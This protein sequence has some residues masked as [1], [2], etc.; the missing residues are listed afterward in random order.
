M[1]VL[2]TNVLAE[3]LRPVPSAVVLRW[4]ADQEPASVFITAITQAEVL[5]GVE[6]LP[7]GKRRERLHHAVEKLITDDFRDRILSFDERAGP[8]FA[9]IV[10]DRQATGRP[11]PQLDAMIAAIARSHRATVATRNIADFVH[12]GVRV[13]NPWDE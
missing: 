6:I 11:A 4:L 3:V 13:I 7:A 8:I 12:C 5:Y 9:K 2:D 10:A 1:I